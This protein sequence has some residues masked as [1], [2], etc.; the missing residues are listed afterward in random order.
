MDYKIDP[1]LCVACLACVRVCPSDA[2]AVENE[3]V[4]IVE[5]AC[6]R[7]GL[8]LPACPHEAIIAVG[9]STRALDLAQSRKAVLILS[10]ESAA[11]FYPATPE[12]VVNACY[13]AGFSVVHRGVLGDELVAKAYLD[14]WAEEGWG[15]RGTVIR[16]TCPVIVETIRNQYPELIPHLAPVATPIAAEARYLKALYGEDTPV[17]YAG[18][19]LTEG[20]DDVDA[21]IT[22]VELETLLRKRG[23][24]VQDQALF[25]SRIP[26]ERRRYWSTAGG[27]PLEL[28]KEERH[29]SRRFRKVRGLAA[30]EG[31]ARAVGT[32]RIDL[33]FVDILP[34][35]GCLDHPLLGPKDELFRRRAIVGATEPPRAPAPVLKEG[36]QIR[37]GAAFEVEMNGVGP[38]VEAVE[39]ILQQIGL[40]PNGRP[41][42]SG[43]CG[44]QTCQEFAVAA[45]QGRTT[46]KSCPRYLER[47]AEEAQQQAAVDALT[48]L[49]SFRVLRDR[50]A[51]EVA[52]CHRTGDRFAVLFLDLDNFKQV[53]DRYGHEAGNA[54]LKATARECDKHIR[55]TD[56]A[57]RYGGD[58]FVIIL[59]GT[60]VAGAR[61]VAE[62]MRL[63]VEQQGLG[64]G[65][66]AGFVTASVGVAE[67]GPEKREEDVLVAADRALYRAKAGGRN[68]VA[69]SGEEPAT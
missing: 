16:S 51:N 55:L 49:A 28:L 15:E 59:V 36:V 19:C 46:L 61:V 56:V 60:G 45:A 58:E 41:W 10:V 44:Y 3:K 23:V 67:Y 7:V 39:S 14:L 65:Y 11:H 8:C 66:A 38:T 68:R 48:G 9:D 20:G 42:D 18:V 2:V 62:K 47:Q 63:A 31:I 69:M 50:L 32:D 35:E 25:F 33:G 6:T 26:E 13:A 12:Q 43:A 34:C 54:L 22:L 52:R 37:V 5:E 40:A 21:A 27:L 57:G 4:W 24:R 1:D 29:A 53:N 30:L 64:M 17:V